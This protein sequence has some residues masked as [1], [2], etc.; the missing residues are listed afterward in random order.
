MRR[1]SSLLCTL[2]QVVAVAGPLT[3]AAPVVAGEFDCL[4]E[5]RQTVDVRS[6]VEAVIEKVHVKRGDFV[7]KGDVLVTLESGA[8]KAALALAQSRATMQGEINAAEARLQLARKKWQQAQELY[9]QKFVSAT[10]RDEAV[11]E[12]KLATEQLRQ[13]RENKVLAQLEVKRSSEILALRTIRSPLSG[14]VVETVLSPG[15][16]ATSNLKDPI[17]RLVEFNPLNVEVILPV[18]EFGRIKTG[19]K[20][21]VLPEE[22]IG[23]E[24]TATVKIVDRIVDAAS[25][26]FGVRLELPNRRGGIPPG[27]RCRVRFP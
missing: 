20:A 14:V 9:E 25:G 22:P 7:R 26:T 2:V 6:S 18:G 17:L 5:A 13:A 8:E 4:I 24:Y 16:F 23:G 12:Y 10:A 1:V 27:V 3:F 21:I 11:A 19:T 15:E